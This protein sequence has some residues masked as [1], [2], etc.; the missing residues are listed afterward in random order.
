[1]FKIGCCGFPVSMEQYFKT[2]SVTEVQRTFYK[3]PGEETLQKWREKAPKDF[4]FTVKAW[5]LITHNPN[6]PTYKKASINIPDEKKSHYGSFNPTPE[7]LEAWET[8]NTVCKILKAKI[9]L[10]Q[11]PASFKPSEENIKNMKDFFSTIKRGDLLFVWEPRGKNWTASLVKSL[12]EKLDITHA[13]DPFA[14]NPTYLAQDTAYLR[15]HGSPPGRKMYQYTYSDDD[16]HR[17]RDILQAINAKQCYLLFN[18]ISMK[19]DALRFQK[20]L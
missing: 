13:V 3:P 16:F 4:E 17:L 7:V 6:S 8:I 18:N 20:L 12:C 2:F 15:L 19:D 5:Q 11:C 14:S 1:M 9:C 10:F